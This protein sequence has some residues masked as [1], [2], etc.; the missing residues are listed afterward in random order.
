M[1]D[2]NIKKM[3]EGNKVAGIRQVSRGI[4]KGAISLVLIADDTDAEIKRQLL[5]LASANNVPII[6]CESR[7]ELG[8]EI[9]IE[10]PCSAVG[11][12]RNQ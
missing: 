6:T 1:L 12:L 2:L 3:L 7:T 9:N 11:F 4:R 5:Q 8:A 10:K